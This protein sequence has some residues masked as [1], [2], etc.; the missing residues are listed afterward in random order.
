M[1]GIALNYD[2]TNAPINKPLDPVPSGWYNARI[3]ETEQL[4]TNKGDGHYL[5]V[6]SE[7]IDGP[8][9]GRKLFDQIN[10]WNPN[11]VAMEI[12][13]KTLGAIQHATG[14]LNMQ[15]TDQ[16][17]NIPLKVKAKLNGARTETNPD[18]TPG[19]SYEASNDVKGYDHINSQHDVVTAPAGGVAGAPVG[20][21][22]WSAP[23]APVPAS[24]PAPAAGTPAW[25]PPAAAAAPATPGA[26]AWTPP[27]GGQ[28]WSPPAGA[29]PAGPPPVAAAPPAAPVDP[30]TLAVA[31][32]WQPHPQAPGNH[33][34]G[35][36]VVP[37]DA[38]RA[39]YGA[40]PAAQAPPAPAAAPA[41]PAWTP[42]AAAAG[43][44]PAAASAP[45][46]GQVPPWAR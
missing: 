36:D 24:A 32:G 28:P 40:Q 19:K 46:G 38:L 10:L 44:A 43:G 2:A 12:A 26:P 22:P 11:P 1:A 5:K 21:P 7:V 30:L 39:H 20:A 35:T 23:G 34:R 31:D 42:P 41:A 18:G 14:I 17:L 25:A 3:I 27:T 8:F 29:A 13:Y 37:D 16:L 45:A 15:H 4:P 33:W 6:T 9:A